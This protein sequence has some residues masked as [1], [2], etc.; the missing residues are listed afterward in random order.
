[1]RLC[2]SIKAFI[3]TQ[4]GFL[5]RIFHLQAHY[6]FFTLQ[7]VLKTMKC[8][9][10][11]LFFLSQWWLQYDKDCFTSTLTYF[12]DKH[13]NHKIVSVYDDDY[14]KLR[15]GV[16]KSAI[17]I[18]AFCQNRVG[19]WGLPKTIEGSM[20]ASIKNDEYIF[21]CMYKYEEYEE[22]MK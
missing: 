18:L 9:L 4:F 17:K 21:T 8:I 12:L 1:M 20:K 3:K 22:M 6:E 15:E 19:G 5:G 11:G 10:K 16:I 14:T 2:T 13:D 7:I